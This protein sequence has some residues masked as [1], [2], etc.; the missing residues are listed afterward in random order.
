MAKQF[1]T[2]RERQALWTDGFI[3]GKEDFGGIILAAMIE[4]GRTRI[5][6]NELRDIILAQRRD[7]P[8]MFLSEHVQEL[9][10]EVR[11]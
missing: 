11:K 5:T 4:M 9:L 10:N 3:A 1:T 8:Q 6:L 7:L 2:A